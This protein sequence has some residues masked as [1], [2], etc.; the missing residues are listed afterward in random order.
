MKI[1]LTAQESETMFHNALCNGLDYMSRHGFNFDYKKSDYESAKR[2]LKEANPS[3][4][5]C[6]EDILMQILREGG[7]LT[8]TDI[9]GDGEYT[10]SI[11]LADV[12]NRVQEVPLDF[13]RAMINEE[14]DADTADVFLQIVFFEEII[15]S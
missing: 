12:H 9:H 13:L 15:F 11:S 7:E 8:M 6:Y 5:I 10:R 3:H 4:T 2:N 1:Q 14:D